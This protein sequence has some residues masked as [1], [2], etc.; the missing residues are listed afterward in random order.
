M[1]NTN[2]T[3]TSNT[4]VTGDLNAS[5]KVGK[6]GKAGGSAG[7]S[8]NSDTFDQATTSKTT[9]GTEK[10]IVHKYSFTGYAQIEVIQNGK[11]YQTTVP[12]SGEM[13]STVHYRNTNNFKG[14]PYIP[15]NI[16]NRTR[17]KR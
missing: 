7:G 12:I 10:D 11:P 1:A 8:Y 6:V 16:P 2:K 14:V 5:A 17:K 3:N 15:H 4:N 13:H 9:T